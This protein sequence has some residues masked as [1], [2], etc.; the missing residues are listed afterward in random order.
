MIALS[1]VRSSCDIDA[2]NADLCLLAT[3]SSWLFCRISLTSRAF[4]MAI[5][6][7]SA[8]VL[9]Q[10]DVL[11]GERPGT[12]ASD[13]D[14]PDALALPQHRR[15]DRRR[16]LHRAPT[17]CAPT[18]APSGVPVDIGVVH[19]RARRDRD[20][21]GLVLSRQRR[22]VRSMSSCPGP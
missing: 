8:K 16:D 13:E 9:Q 22:I 15:A 20:A 12:V 11:V 5:T 7:W 18:S 4:W 2:R 10:R 14:R 3:S 21:G 6:A 1:G 19:D 17:P